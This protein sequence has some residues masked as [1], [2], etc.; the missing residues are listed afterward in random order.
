MKLGLRRRF[1]RCQTCLFL[2]ACLMVGRAALRAQPEA[3][4]AVVRGGATATKPA[5]PA[6]SNAPAP[7]ASLAPRENA[8]P[9][10]RPKAGSPADAAS[11]L[12]DPFR[13]P[14]EE[15]ATG[16]AKPAAAKPRPPGL[17]GLLVEQLRLQGIVRE[18]VSHRMIAMVAGQS[19]LSYFLH[20]GDRLY[21]GEVSR[22][23]PDTLYIR[24]TGAAP[25]AIPNEIALR[26]GPGAG[27]QE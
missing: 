27:G 13:A 20:E 3:A 26:I 22:I 7:A 12:R 6:P 16:S 2:A 21:D 14:E 5:S 9:S 17:R 10:P 23:T 24:R 8:L 15:K 25:P 4:T 1:V 18:E 19:N 11:H